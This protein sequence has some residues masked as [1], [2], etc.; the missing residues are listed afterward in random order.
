MSFVQRKVS[1]VNLMF[2]NLNAKALFSALSNEIEMPCSIVEEIVKVPYNIKLDIQLKDN[3]I[4]IFG[5]FIT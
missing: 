3:A 2:G 5:Y 4:F 1:L